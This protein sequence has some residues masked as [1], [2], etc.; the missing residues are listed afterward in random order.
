VFASLNSVPA[1]TSLKMKARQMFST[2]SKGSTVSS[3]QDKR[4]G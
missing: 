3:L 4:R 1:K 2:E